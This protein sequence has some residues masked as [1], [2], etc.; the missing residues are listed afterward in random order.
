M[1]ASG[2]P[3]EG[4]CG[5]KRARVVER[6]RKRRDF[7]AAAT[8]AKVATPAFI[9]QVRQR[10]DNKPVRVGF[11]VSRKVGT[12]VERNRARRRLKEVVRFFAAAGLSAGHD[13][14]LVARR[15]ALSLPFEQISRDLNRALGRL[16]V[17]K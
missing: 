5:G 7:L 9:L 15:S 4:V 8:G 10:G 1:D 13:Y 17:A 16:R 2:S 6:L 3:P 12:A 14:V 11:T